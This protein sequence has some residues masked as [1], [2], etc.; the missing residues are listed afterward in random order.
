MLTK[1]CSRCQRDLPLDQF[2]KNKAMRDG[3][4]AWCTECLYAYRNDPV[5]YQQYR[6]VDNKRHNH[7][8]A[9]DAEFKQRINER[10]NAWCREQWHNN[11]EYRARKNAQKAVARTKPHIR[12]NIR[13]W[14]RRRSQRR[15]LWAKQSPTSYT[16]AEWLG[17]CAKYKYRCVCCGKRR[18]LTVDHIVPLSRGG[19]NG[20]ENIQPLC[21]PCNQKKFT[22]TIDYRPDKDRPRPVQLSFF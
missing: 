1:H 9:T 15:R 22:H 16:K 4:Q 6:E 17:L 19:S 20:I 10:N 12:E 13:F 3:L 5:R 14:A 18:P 21:K 2:K 7:R 8:Y 11:P